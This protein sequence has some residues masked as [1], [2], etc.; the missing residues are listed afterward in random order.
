VTG[1]RAALLAVPLALAACAA[2]APLT[3]PPLPASD[4]PTAGAT[5]RAEALARL[6]PPAEVRASDLGDVLVYRRL[7]IVDGNPNRYYGE[8]RG[9]RRE[10]YERV[11]LYLDADGR[12]VRWSTELE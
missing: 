1:A 12:V 11:L 6:G 5:T 3:R 10:R 2:L 9:A 8:E 4:D 7:A